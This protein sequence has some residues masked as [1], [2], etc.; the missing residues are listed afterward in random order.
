LEVDALQAPF[1]LQSRGFESRSAAWCEGPE[2]G[3]ERCGAS[4]KG[5]KGAA[6]VS[7]CTDRIEFVS[8][9]RCL[10]SRLSSVSDILGATNTL[11]FGA[12][13]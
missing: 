13:L 1:L 9:V 8:R 5:R 3:A 11:S 6:V 2:H 4:G 10:G 12:L 7:S